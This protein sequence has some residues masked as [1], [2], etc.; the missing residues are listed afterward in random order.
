M[1]CL[2]QGLLTLRNVTVWPLNYR[3]IQ[4]ELPVELLKIQIKPH[5]QLSSFL[6]LKCMFQFFPFLFPVRV[7]FDTFTMVVNPF[8]DLSEASK[9]EVC[10]FFFAYL[11]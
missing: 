8:P 3:V 7:P 2:L 9:E 6:S 1:F 4:F 11:L 5:T 10:C